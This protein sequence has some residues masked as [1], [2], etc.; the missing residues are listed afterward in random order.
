[1]TH[2]YEGVSRRAFLS[3]IAGTSIA[4]SLEH[5]LLAQDAKGGFSDCASAIKALDDLPALKKKRIT[6][7]QAKSGNDT[8][9]V[10]YLDQLLVEEYKL[11]AD[12]KRNPDGFVAAWY[13]WDD[14]NQKKKA[15]EAIRADLKSIG[16]EDQTDDMVKGVDTTMYYYRQIVRFRGS[17]GHRQKLTYLLASKQLFEDA[18]SE[19]EMCSFIDEAYAEH[20]AREFNI[21]V[22]G[23]EL[24]L[25][26]S[27][28]NLRD[29][30]FVSL[31]AAR[32]RLE[33]VLNGKRKN[34]SQFTE[35]SVLRN[36][37]KHYRN[38][39]EQ[40]DACAA[41]TTIDV[42]GRAVEDPFVRAAYD[43]M[44][45]FRAECDERLAKYGCAW[46]DGKLIRK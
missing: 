3:T 40:Q 33:L 18:H 44:K 16:R 12:A 35:D 41:R 29:T 46:K 5:M 45:A 21:V 34:M 13:Y 24:D 20:A 6:F 2:N 17:M 32:A 36:Y 10:A 9:K 30:D 23:K 27:E 15:V 37:A 1:M 38:F 19:D 7:D 8:K 25:K 22:G 42:K 28:L 39:A 31:F 26:N 14:K 11:I 4:Y 43:T